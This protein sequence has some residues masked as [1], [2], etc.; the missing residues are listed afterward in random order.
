ME[1]E[2][3]PSARPSVSFAD[4]R[5]LRLYHLVLFW[6]DYLSFRLAIPKPETLFA[7]F[8]CP[9]AMRYVS[10]PFQLRRNVDIDGIVATPIGQILQHLASKFPKPRKI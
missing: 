2:I 1:Y 5:G 6:V 7:A 3:V 8:P 4:R 9:Q 10:S